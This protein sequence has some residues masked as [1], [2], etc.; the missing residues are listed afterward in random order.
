[1]MTEYNGTKQS[2][3]LG[4]KLVGDNIHKGVKA[5]YMRAE[6]HRNQSLHYFHCFAIQNRIDHSNYPGV[7][8]PTCKDSPRHR[9]LALLPSKEDDSTLWMNIAVLVSRV[10]AEYMPFFKHTFD[11]V[12]TWHIKH[13]HTAE[14]SSKSL[15]VR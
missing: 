11:D 1:M 9:A 4:Y 13:Q 14:M 5:R 10:L 6:V 3:S 2:L 12:V 7:H 8:P 15:V